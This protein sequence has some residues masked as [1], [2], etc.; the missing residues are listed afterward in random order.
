MYIL[1]AFILLYLRNNIFG[2]REDNI[3]HKFISYR[4][5][6]P[7]PHMLFYF[8][9]RWSSENAFFFRKK[10]LCPQIHSNNFQG[11]RKSKRKDI[12]IWCLRYTTRVVIRY[13]I[14][15]VKSDVLQIRQ[16]KIR[17]WHCLLQSSFLFG[18]IF[19][20]KNAW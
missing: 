5:L 8:S 15:F 13:F 6:D 2:I 18:C 7:G 16:K 12:N 3:V 4:F 1:V 17:R 10:K 9:F 20:E 14:W 19:L 11:A